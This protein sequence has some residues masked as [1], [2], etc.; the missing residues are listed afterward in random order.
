MLFLWGE[1]I[2]TRALR[3][4][5]GQQH[6]LW[7]CSSSL[8]RTAPQTWLPSKPPFLSALLSTGN[9]VVKP[10]TGGFCL[11]FLTH[12][13][14]DTPAGASSGSTSPAAPAPAGGLSALPE[15]WE[16]RTAPDG[17]IY[18]VNHIL[19]C[20]QWNDPRAPAPASANSALGPLPQGWELRQ[21]P[22][23]RPYFVDHNTRTTTF[24]GYL[25]V[26]FVYP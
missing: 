24:Q 15:G 19:R 17:R 25:P 18:F 26:I 2:T 21:T 23:G 5:N 9:V 11:N 7:R 1:K 10:P 8:M 22:Q 13:E 6:R 4:G 12:F 14:P 16:Q 3:H 20:T